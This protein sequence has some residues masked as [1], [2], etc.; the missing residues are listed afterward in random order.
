MVAKTQMRH[1]IVKRDRRRQKP[2]GLVGNTQRTRERERAKQEEGP[3]GPATSL[4]SLHRGKHSRSA[5]SF[6]SSTLSSP[7]LTFS[8]CYF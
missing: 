4:R 5:P 8:F 3:V 2:L 7:F 1:Y 6:Y